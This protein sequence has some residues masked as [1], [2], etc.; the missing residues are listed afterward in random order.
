MQFNIEDTTMGKPL[1]RRHASKASWIRDAFNQSKFSDIIDNIEIADSISTITDKLNTLTS[2]D[3]S[4]TKKNL[5]YL[6]KTYIDT[7]PES[8]SDLDISRAENHI[9]TLLSM[10][11]RVRERAEDKGIEF[12][13]TIEQWDWLRQQPCWYSGLK[14]RPQYLDATNPGTPHPTVSAN[15]IDRLDSSKGYTVDN[16]VP[17]HSD[18][19]YLKLELKHNDF[20]AACFILIKHCPQFSQDVRYIMQGNKHLNNIYHMYQN[21]ECKG[22]NKPNPEFSLYEIWALMTLVAHRHNRKLF[23][24]FN[25][26]KFDV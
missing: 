20:I 10:Y 14:P 9:V 26:V 6:I 2:V 13:L 22:I 7:L 15:G 3:V 12:N 4:D 23:E 5:T 21:V 1:I 11:K 19:N 25:K 24:L 16:V 18:I 17:C 8:A